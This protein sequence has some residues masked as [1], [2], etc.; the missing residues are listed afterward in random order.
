MKYYQELN[1][2]AKNLAWQLE[3]QGYKVNHPNNEP[4][5][6]PSPPTSPPP[7]PKILNRGCLIELTRQ[8]PIKRHL[9]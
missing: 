5:P 2:Y 7:P 6:K 4:Y 1:I 3:M 9:T 8:S